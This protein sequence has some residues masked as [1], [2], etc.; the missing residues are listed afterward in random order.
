MTTTR[1]RAV[2]SSSVR[3]PRCR[4]VGGTGNRCTGEV[5]DPDPRALQICPRHALKAAQLL[6]EAGAIAITYANIG[7]PA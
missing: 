2:G 3:A 6:A 5:V 4:M 7:R 1:D